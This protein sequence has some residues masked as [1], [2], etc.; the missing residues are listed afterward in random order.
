MANATA[1]D[2]VAAELEERSSL[3][4]LEARG[5]VRLALK[6]AGLD[7]AQVT[8]QQMAVVLEKVLPGELASRGI[9]D[10]QGI[11]AAL[12]ARLAGI[13]AGGKTAETPEDVF[14]RLG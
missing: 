10:A 2:L 7:A 11:C 1:F 3:S 4:Q 12:A 9:E 13:E 8:P 5:T 14:A 6:G